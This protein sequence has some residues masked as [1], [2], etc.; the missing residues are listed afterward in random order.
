MSLFDAPSSSASPAIT[1]PLGDGNKPVGETVEGICNVLGLTFDP[2]LWEDEPWAIEEAK[3]KGS[4]PV[5]RPETANDDEDD[6]ADPFGIAVGTG[7]P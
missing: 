6:D 5:D 1:V 2:A 3:A 7:P 4:P